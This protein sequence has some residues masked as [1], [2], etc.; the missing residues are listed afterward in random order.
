MTDIYIAT[1]G[2][3]SDYRVA[4]AF[5]NEEAAMEF[6]SSGLADDY[7]GL[8]LLSAAPK[9][10]RRKTLTYIYDLV[11]GELGSRG[12]GFSE[13]VPEALAKPMTVMCERQR[14]RL[15]REPTPGNP[16]PMGSGWY[17]QDKQTLWIQVNSVENADKARKAAYDAVAKWKVK[18]AGL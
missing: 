12:P 11:T 8:P 18:Q 1:V 6:V 3:Y 15:Y 4:G 16:Q 7:F 2:E 13:R 14:D 17:W 9:A 10:V 5:D